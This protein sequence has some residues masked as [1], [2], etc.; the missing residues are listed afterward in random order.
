MKIVCQTCGEEYPRSGLPY[1]CQKCGGLYEWDSI[2]DYPPKKA[3]KD[4]D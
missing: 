4:A 1:H 3:K 2:I